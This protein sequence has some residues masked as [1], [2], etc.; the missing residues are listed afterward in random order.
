MYINLIKS[1]GTSLPILTK[2][3]FWGYVLG[4][5]LKTKLYTSILNGSNLKVKN[6]Q[7]IKSASICKASAVE[8]ESITTSNG[9]LETMSLLDSS[10]S[11]TSLFWDH[12]NENRILA[13]SSTSLTIFDINASANESPSSHITQIT[14]ENVIEKAAWYPHSAT[15][16]GVASGNT[17][18]EYDTRTSKP[19]TY[20]TN[21]SYIRD[22]DYNPNKMRTLATADEFGVVRIY[23]TRNCS[24]L[25]ETRDHSHWVTCVRFNRFHDELLLSSGT[26]CYVNLESIVSVSSNIASSEEEEEEERAFRFFVLNLGC[27]KTFF[28]LIASRLMGW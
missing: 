16:I 17:V 2:L 4:K 23:D 11:I 13:V 28:L 14:T 9:D 6:N 26:D 10:L 21:D 25:L 24:K 1:A 7:F 15:Q 18:Q 19:T 8:E 22:I 3:I 5:V 27:L 12:S 20:I